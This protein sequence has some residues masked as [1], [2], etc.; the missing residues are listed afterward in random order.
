MPNDNKIMAADTEH[1]DVNN[2]REVERILRDAGLSKEKAKAVLARGWKAVG[3]TDIDS[4]DL[5]AAQKLMN[6]FKGK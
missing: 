6:R 3:N 2:I 1:K 5:E 4:G